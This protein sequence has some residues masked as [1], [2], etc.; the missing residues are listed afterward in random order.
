MISSADKRNTYELLKNAERAYELAL[1]H[2]ESRKAGIVLNAFKE[3]HEKNNPAYIYALQKLRRLPVTIEEFIESPEFLGTGTN[4][5]V[6]EIWEPLIPLI[7]QMNPDILSGQKNP[8]EVLM[9]GASGCHAKGTQILM[10]DGT[11]KYVEDVKVNDYL[12]GPD[13]NV[14]K[15]LNLARGRETMYKI[16][17][18]TGGEPFIVNENHL[19]YLRSKRNK[20]VNFTVMS[21]KEFVSLSRYKREQ[22]Y[23]LV[24]YGVTEFPNAK[25][26]EL[27]L[28]PYYLGL[29]LGDG[30]SRSASVTIM[31]LEIKNAVELEFLRLGVKTRIETLENNKASTYHASN[32]NFSLTES[33][34]L[35][36]EY[37]LLQNKHIPLDYKTASVNNRLS[38]LAGII[39]SDGSLSCNGYEITFKNKKLFDDVV[40]L[41]RSLGF[42]VSTSSKIVKN[43]TYFRMMIT[44]NVD[45]IPVRIERKK[46][47][48]RRQIKDWQVSGFTCEKLPEDDFYG[49]ALSDDHLY[50]SADFTVHHNTGKTV[51]SVVSNLYQ[52]YVADCFDWPQDM[53][54]LSRPTEIVFLFLSIKPSTAEKVMYKPFRQ[55]FESMPYTRKYIEYN[56]DITSELRLNNNKTVRFASA[57]VNSLIGHAV[58]SGGIDEIN[59]FARVEKSKQTPD[60]GTFDQADLVHKTLLNRRESRFTSMGPNPGLICISAQTKYKGDF[61]DRRLE[62]IRAAELKGKKPNVMWFREKRYD[63]V[64]KERLTKETFQI[65][66]GT[67][68]YPTRI[69][70]PESKYALPPNAVIENVP[71]TYYDTF[72]RDPE[73]G[74]REI[75][76]IATNAITPFIPQR[77]KIH[78][79][80]VAW[81]ERE[82]LLPWTTESNYKLNEYSKLDDKGMP[83][84]I[85]D[86]LPKDNKARYVHVDLGISS[87]RCGISICHIDGYVDI[88]GERLPYY[89]VDWVVTLEPDSIN[90][91]DIAEVR[92]WVSN[93]KI[94]YGLNIARVSYD[95]YQSTES[96]Q[97]LRKLGINSMLVS[98]DKTLE[99]YEILRS[100]LYTNRA[101][102]PDNELL[103]AELAG[104]ELNMN[105]NQGKGKVDHTPIMGKDAAD[106]VCGAL[107][108][109]SLSAAARMNIGHTSV[110]NTRPS[111]PARPRSRGGLDI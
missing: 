98:V 60:G 27:K 75:V 28:S 71:M 89:V 65:L 29:W 7:C 108:N 70:D 38:L 104:L 94:K 54:Q 26:Q 82:V 106:A 86:N 63:V 15:V 50:L 19:L 6:L 87:D 97:M 30:T 109:A 45:S 100:A 107:Y 11:I 76:G 96:M 17:P 58:M 110:I 53:F 88:N 80:M 24:R 20:Q 67:D 48:P 13:G 59:Y 8:D 56:K 61:T 10:A 57:N 41:A 21:V 18:H 16:T 25:R 44:G 73:H 33:K 105:A 37:N 32:G 14:R 55:Y 103:K 9:L 93:L 1:K 51:R 49:F 43:T 39:D 22:K 77:H 64:P 4:R 99:P 12:L 92:R 111:T 36:R 47:L 40:F 83:K 3:L 72:L 42:C 35:L 79:S 31:D 34:K 102:L 85:V 90:Q 23:K 5:P 69:I 81:S 95:G 66:V 2:G 46:A 101:A 62:E 78:E 74:L 52:L 91:V 84:V 68:E